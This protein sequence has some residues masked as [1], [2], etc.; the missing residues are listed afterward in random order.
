MFDLTEKPGRN[1]P[2]SCESGK[3]FKHCCAASATPKPRSLNLKD[4]EY[5]AHSAV[6]AGDF[7]TAEQLFRKLLQAKPRDAFVL[8]NLGQAL[9]WIKRKREGLHYLLQAAK[10]LQRQLNKSDDPRF[11]I[12]LSSQLLHWG[13]VTMAETLARLAVKIKPSSPEALNNLAMCLTRIN[14]HEEALLISRRVCELLPKQPGANILLAM[15][16]AK[17]G[18]NSQ[19]LQRLVAVIT[20]NS[21]PE[22]TARAWLEMGVI[23]DKQGRYAEAFNAMSLAANAHSSLINYPPA[24][25]DFIFE[26]IQCNRE[27]FDDAL[28][29]RWSTAEICNDGLPMPAFLLGFLRSG[30]TLTEQVLDAH[31]DLIATDE[32]TILHEMGQELARMSGVENNHGRALGSITLEKIAQLRQ[33]YWRRMREEYGNEVM[34][35]QLVDKNA[36]NT[37]DLGLISVVFPEAKILFALRDPRDVAISC[38]M[39]AFSPS[40]ATV[41]LL[42]WQ[43]IGRQYEAIMDYWLHLRPLIQP[44]ILEIRYE[45]LVTEFEICYRGVFEFL[46]LPWAQRVA[47]FHSNAKR[48]YIS[49]PSFAAVSQPIYKSAIARWRNYEQPMQELLPSLGRFIV[50]FG[51]PA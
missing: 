17:T 47:N 34:R 26:S 46:D 7:A 49:T 11:A 1:A 23:L 8:A 10:L 33:F 41:N 37:I 42:S 5:Q 30:T 3:K 38:Y 22:Q 12:E 9:C 35:K 48:R 45:D 13:E 18:D 14:C 6:V 43:G 2:C 29:N 44:K 15:I 36:L 39:Q 31:P 40:P 28:L 20:E 16:E 51:Y 27:S 21:D 19:S 50:E 25:R 32:S 24:M 4:L